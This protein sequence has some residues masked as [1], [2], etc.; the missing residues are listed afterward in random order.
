MVDHMTFGGDAADAGTGIATLVVEAGAV[1]R[2]VTVQ[3]ALGAALGVR[4]SVVLRQAQAGAHAIALLAHRIGAAGTRV[5]G[6]SHLG[7]D[8]NWG[9]DRGK[10]QRISI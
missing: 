8:N 5:A 1:L 9:R 6:L 3:H 2:A 10:G 4:V 7:R